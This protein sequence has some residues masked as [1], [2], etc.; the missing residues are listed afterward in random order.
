MKSQA[1]CRT[2][3]E[4]MAVAGRSCILSRSGEKRKAKFVLEL[5]DG[6]VSN[7]LG[8]HEKYVLFPCPA[9]PRLLLPATMAYST[10][11]EASWDV[12][13]ELEQQEAGRASLPVMEKQ[14]AIDVV[15]DDAGDSLE[16]EVPLV[17]AL[18]PSSVA[19]Q[20]SAANVRRRLT[21]KQPPPA[22][23]RTGQQ[24]W[25]ALPVCWQACRTSRTQ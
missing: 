8:C 19:E 13:R 20:P 14:G 3:K 1:Q 15:A 2:A 11:D 21:C 7:A 4:P 6:H 25:K 22:C 9:P 23:H 12:L 17:A 16:P 24:A 5:L 18:A 10:E